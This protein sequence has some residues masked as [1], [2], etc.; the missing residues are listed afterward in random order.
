MIRDNSAVRR[1]WFSLARDDADFNAATGEYWRGSVWV[2]TAY[3]TV[4][5]LE[6]YGYFTLARDTAR[7]VVEHMYLT[8]RDYAPHTIWECYNPSKSEPA[9]SCGE[10]QQ[11]V[12]PDFCGWSA[13][14]PI[15]L[16]LEN[17]IGIYSADAFAKVVKWQLDLQG[18]GKIGV[19][20]FRFGDTVTDLVYENGG[21][22]SFHQP[23]VPVGG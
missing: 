2:P 20:N 9:H 19:R 17:V 8:F 16:Y 13:L 10:N 12:R 18:Q 11:V 23:A 7:K 1:R 14:A 4:K 3:M 5:G 6:N 15:G 22:R 21:L